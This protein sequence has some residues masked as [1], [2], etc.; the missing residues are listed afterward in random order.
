MIMFETDSQG[1]LSQQGCADV[2]CTGQNNWTPRSHLDGFKWFVS[3]GVSASGLKETVDVGMYDPSGRLV[4]APLEPG[5]GQTF[6][7]LAQSS[8]GFGCP[9]GSGPLGDS[10]GPSLG[11]GLGHNVSWSFPSANTIEWKI[12]YTLVWRAGLEGAASCMT[13]SKPIVN[14][15]SGTSN[16]IRNAV[17]FSW[18]DH[19]IG[20]PEPVGLILGWTWYTDSVPAV[21]GAGG[22]KVGTPAGD[23]NPARIAGPTCPF[24]LR[25]VGPVTPGQVN[26]L[27]NP[28]AACMIPNPVGPG[29]NSSGIGVNAT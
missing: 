9:S 6:G 19:E 22:Y 14:F 13:R 23:P 3:F 7:V 5:I 27:W 15:T 25:S 24:T 17:A 29:F 11:A 26:P 28:N 16:Q 21:G 8:T 4:G 1:Q 2:A 12:P 10:Q 20:G 18:A